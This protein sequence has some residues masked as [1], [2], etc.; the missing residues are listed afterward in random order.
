MY[1][2]N[3]KAETLEKVNI[4]IVVDCYKSKWIQLNQKSIAYQKIMVVQSEQILQYVFYICFILSIIYV[5][6]PP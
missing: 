5:Q 4:I 1:I 6:M 3:S 2:C